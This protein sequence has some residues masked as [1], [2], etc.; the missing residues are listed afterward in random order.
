[1]RIWL[2]D[3]DWRRWRGTR[4]VGREGA[5]W[6][7]DLLGFADYFAVTAL[8][9]WRYCVLDVDCFVVTVFVLGVF[10]SVS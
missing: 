3:R 4:G 9:A 10:A 2:R 7:R 1:M 6:G 8:S 5:G